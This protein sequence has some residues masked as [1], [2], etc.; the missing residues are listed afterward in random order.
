VV[1]RALRS[2]RAPAEDSVALDA[3]DPASWKR[4]LEG[5]DGVISCLGA[6]VSPHLRERAGFAVFD[7]GAHRALARALRDTGAARAVYLSAH[8]GPGFDRTRYLRAHLEAEEVLGSGAR[9]LRVVRPTGIFTA[10]DAFLGMARSGL[11]FVTGDGRARTNPIHP[12]DVA[13]AV[14]AALDDASPAV[15]PV[16]GPEILTRQE[17]VELAFTS[18]GKRPRLVHSPAFGLRA[19][20]RVLRP[21]HPRLGELMEFLVEVSVNDAC[22]PAVGANRLGDWF[23]AR[24]AQPA[25]FTA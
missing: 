12:D 11:G 20:S 3:M 25:V 15:N 23:R 4:A 13:D 24:S 1:R 17:I 8:A 19:L 2:S 18:L 5:A 9:S 6:S 16:G 22:A 21:L 7:V 10:F 14:V